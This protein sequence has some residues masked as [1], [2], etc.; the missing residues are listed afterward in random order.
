MEL[1]SCGKKT[2]IFPLNFFFQYFIFK[3]LVKESQETLQ[4]CVCFSVRKKA[5]VCS[6]QSFE[7]CFQTACKRSQFVS[8]SKK[9]EMLLL[10]QNTFL[11]HCLRGVISAVLKPLLTQLH[12]ISCFHFNIGGYEHKVHGAY[13]FCCAPASLVL[14]KDQLEKTGFGC[15]ESWMAGCIWS[16]K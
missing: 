13:F 6:P 7:L 14:P 2:I 9:S 5:S 16:F 8:I 1:H 3:C 4:V 11:E 15:L 12:H 10:L